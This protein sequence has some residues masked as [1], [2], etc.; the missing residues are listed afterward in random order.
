MLRHIAASASWLRWAGER[1]S[2]LMA[3]SEGRPSTVGDSSAGLHI[4]G[5]AHLES[6]ASR[7]ARASGVS[8]PVIFDI[9]SMSWRPMVMA[10][11]R[12]RSSSVKVPSGF[13]QSASLSANTRSSSGPNLV[14]CSA[15]SASAL[16]RADS[17][18]QLGRWWKKRPISATWAVLICPARWAAAVAG[19]C[20]GSGSPVIVVRAPSISASAMR[21]RASPGRMRSRAASVFFSDLPICSGVACAAMRLMAWCSITGVWQRPVSVASSTAN[22]SATPSASNGRFT[23]SVTAPR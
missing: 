13:K 6:T 20:A 1:M 21:R 5:A 11:R 10:R 19:H 22:R 18:T 9:P 16:A 23:N 4:A 17:S 12:A 3:C 8:Q 14:A 15:R 7:L 2:L